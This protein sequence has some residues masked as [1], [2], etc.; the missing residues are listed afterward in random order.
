MEPG[1]P[2]RQDPPTEHSHDQVNGSPPRPPSRRGWMSDSP[3]DGGSGWPTSAYAVVPRQPAAPVEEA[4]PAPPPAHEPEAVARTSRKGR[5]AVL[6]VGLVVL[7]IAVAGGVLATRD[8]SAKDGT[9]AAT[10]SEG[11]TTGKSAVPVTDPA[12]MPSG[13]AEGGG[14]GGA[15]ATAGTSAEPSGSAS[16]AATGPSAGASTPPAAPLATGVLR[17]GTAQLAVLAGRPDEAYD[18]DSG[19][20]RAAGADVTAGVI[21]LSAVNG[22]R[23]AVLLTADTPSLST[24]SAVP[25]GQWTGQVVLASLLPNSKVCVRTSEDR[26]AW[27]MT[28][29]GEAVNGAVYSANLDFIVYKKAGE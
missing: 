23:F 16:G 3:L 25:A 20:K 7:V 2:P 22:A 19:S 18:F 4:A 10:Q 11:A 1:H 8:D 12:A 24:C 27:F 26:Y 21:G 29:A 5:I 17:A 14:V 15:S 28:R 9:G 13:S 6:L